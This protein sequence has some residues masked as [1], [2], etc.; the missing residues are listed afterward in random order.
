MNNELYIT[1]LLDDY[2]RRKLEREEVISL[3]QQ[4]G[5][6]NAGEEIDLHHAAT[7][8]L[9]RGSVLQQVKGVHARFLQN[10]PASNGRTAS[11]RGKLVAMLQP[12]KWVLRI[13]AAAIIIFAG[14]FAYDYLSSSST[15]LY[16]DIYQPYNVNTDRAVIEEIVPHNMV[17]QFKQKDYGGV[18][19]T[20]K[21]LAVPGNREKFLTAMAFQETGGH[22][23]AIELLTQIL[24][25]NAQ[26][27]TRLYN[28]DAEF[29]LAL[30]HLKLKNTKAALA[31]FSKIY[32][33]QGHTYR[34]RISKSMLR[35]MKWIS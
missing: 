3:L 19:A 35:K 32:N 14:W 30:N 4:Q 25:Y 9:Q 15:A 33:D 8:A 17:Q 21:T 26:Q 16:A 5:V 13:A 29:Y 2:V 23:Q 11:G 6:A 34:E 20:Y 22:Q 18:I 7:I 12:V 31:L 28:D 10:Q 24:Q 27:G 1:G